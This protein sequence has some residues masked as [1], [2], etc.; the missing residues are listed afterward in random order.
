MQLLGAAVLAR[1]SLGTGRLELDGGEARLH[2]RGRGSLPV[3]GQTHGFI[4]QG[5]VHC[6]ICIYRSCEVRGS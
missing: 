2:A 1:G 4:D 5:K 6:G 3:A